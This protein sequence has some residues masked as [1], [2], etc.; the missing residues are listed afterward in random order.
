MSILSSEKIDRILDRVKALESELAAGTS[1]EAFVKLSK[2]YADIQP[3]AAAASRYRSALAERAGLEEI[4]GQGGELAEMAALEKPAIEE[5][6]ARIEHEL[7]LFLLPK[8]TAD[9]RNVILEVRA[10]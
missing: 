3:L 6:I 2:D 10:G 4:M 1:G 5:R 7:K 8:D 9:D